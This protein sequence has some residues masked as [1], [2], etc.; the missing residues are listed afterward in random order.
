MRDLTAGMTE[1]ET[2]ATGSAAIS[3]AGAGSMQTVTGTVTGPGKVTGREGKVTN[4][5]DETAT[6]IGQSLVVTGTGWLGS[7]GSGPTRKS[8]Q[9]LTGFPAASKSRMASNSSSQLSRITRH[10]L[11]QVLAASC[12]ACLGLLLWTTAS[13]QRAVLVPAL[14][15]LAAGN[16]I[17]RSATAETLTGPTSQRAL[18]WLI[19]ASHLEQTV[20]CHPNPSL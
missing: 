13:R 14:L 9:A 6:G 18:V 15:Q 19:A 20:P 2:G 7:T 10:P 3:T 4:V 1:S 8:G 12:P 11:Q 16:S 5:I 17:M